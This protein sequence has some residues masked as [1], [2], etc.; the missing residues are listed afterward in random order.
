M[1]FM[2]FGSNIK[3]GKV[4]TFCVASITISFFKGS[5]PT[6]VTLILYA[7]EGTSCNSNTPSALLLA[8]VNKVESLALS[9]MTEANSNICFDESRTTPRTVH[10][11]ADAKNVIVQKKITNKYIF[12]ISIF[13]YKNNLFRPNKEGFANCEAFFNI[14]LWNLEL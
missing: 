12:F 7:P 8:N 11:C 1:S 3:S 4:V 14:Y 5:R 6:Y 2:P 9:N 13:F 10:V